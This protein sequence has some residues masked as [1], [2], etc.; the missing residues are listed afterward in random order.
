MPSSRWKNERSFF[1]RQ[2]AASSPIEPQSRACAGG[3]DRI[4]MCADEGACSGAV[5]I[6]G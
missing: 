3:R 2:A 6:V 5:R 1:Q 4:A